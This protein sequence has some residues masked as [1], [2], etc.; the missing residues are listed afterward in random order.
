MIGMSEQAPALRILLVEDN[1]ID[2][3][4]T[5]E[6][7]KTWEVQNNLH[8]VEDGQEAVDFLYRRGIYR[9]AERPDLILLDL[10][11]PK[12]SGIEVLSAIKQD[13]GLSTIT[14]VVVT[15]SAAV[16][17]LETCNHLGAE[18][19]ITKPLELEEYIRK[20]SSIQELWLS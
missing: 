4:M 3:L 17:D 13:A 19:C 16:A 5:E 7:L 6:A 9:M 11:L 12:K 14:V 15:T 18:R 2:V 10:N 1:P 20:L 8:V